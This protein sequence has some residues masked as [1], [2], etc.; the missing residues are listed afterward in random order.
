M[1]D[2]VGCYILIFLLFLLLPLILSW[3]QGEKVSWL[4]IT[5]FFFISLVSHLISVPV[6]VISNE[7]EEGTQNV[8]DKKCVI[9]KMS[10]K[11]FLPREAWSIFDNRQK[12]KLMEQLKASRLCPWRPW[13]RG[14]LK[15]A[16]NWISC[17]K[18]IVWS[19]SNINKLE[20]NCQ[21][22]RQSHFDELRLKCYN[23]CVNSVRRKKNYLG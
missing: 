21:H 3:V 2:I 11:F 8:K 15:F 6:L 16:Q 22:Q 14:M 17:L 4:G 9:A 1:K 5:V 12:R 18:L 23:F 19:Q 20:W 13:K 7:N 10:K